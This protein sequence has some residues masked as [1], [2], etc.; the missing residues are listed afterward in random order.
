MNNQSFTLVFESDHERIKLINLLHDANPAHAP[1]FT[2]QV[3]GIG[4]FV[5]RSEPGAIYAN[6]PAPEQ[7]KEEA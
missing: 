1:S 4:V 7:P 2:I 6:V 3:A 5:Q